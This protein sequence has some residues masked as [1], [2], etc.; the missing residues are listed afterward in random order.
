MLFVIILFYVRFL[1]IIMMIITLLILK[2]LIIIAIMTVIL[3]KISILKFCF[4][5]AIQD[6]HICFSDVS[7]KARF[8]IRQIVD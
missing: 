4:A 1:N 3:I 5:V 6:T 2:V 7:H 8:S